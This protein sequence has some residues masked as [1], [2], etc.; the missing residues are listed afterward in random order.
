MSD[1]IS[2][3]G[4]M[5]QS[6]AA[7]I[8]SSVDKTGK[9]PAAQTAPVQGGATSQAADKTSSAGADKVSLSNVAQLA[10]DQPGFNRAKVDAIKRDLQE[11]KYAINPRLIAENFVALERMINA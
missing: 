4:R 11:G 8:R 6:N 5:T 7:A 9:K 3:Y 1:A 2:N 10:L